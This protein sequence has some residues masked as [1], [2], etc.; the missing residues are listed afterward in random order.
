MS[1]PSWNTTKPIEASYLVKRTLCVR[2]HPLRALLKMPEELQVGWMLSGVFWRF[3]ACKN[4]AA[5]DLLLIDLRKQYGDFYVQDE[6][7]E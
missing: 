5:F 7:A 2:P 3:G 6:A 4:R 1:A